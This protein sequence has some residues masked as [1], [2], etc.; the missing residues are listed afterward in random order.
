MSIES[1]NARKALKTMAG[2]ER[3][4]SGCLLLLL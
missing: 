1:I 4:L 3:E 2:S